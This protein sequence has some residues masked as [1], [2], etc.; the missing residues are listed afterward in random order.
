MRDTSAATTQGRPFVILDVELERGFLFLVLKN[1]GELPATKVVAKIAPEML[2]PDGK[3]PINGINLFTKLAFFAPGKEFRVLVGS[4]A[5]Y[6]ASAR[7]PTTFTAAISYR[8]QSDKGFS[9]SVTHD[10]LVY[11]DIP[12]SVGRN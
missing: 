10:L 8:D 6:F 12:H 7:Q 3:T 2:G 9:E 11:K 4:A 1:I 5:T